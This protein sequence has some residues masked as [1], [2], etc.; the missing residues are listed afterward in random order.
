MDGRQLGSG[1]A[2]GP[3]HDTLYLAPENGVSDRTLASEVLSSSTNT[4]LGPGQTFTVSATVRVPG[5]TEGP[6][7]WQVHV[8]S[9]GEVFEGV[10]ANNN[11]ASSATPM[12]LTVTALAVESTNSLTFAGEGVASWFKIDQAANQSVLVDLNAATTNGR[13]R[14][15]AGYDTMP[16]TSAYDLRSAAWNSA[17]ARVVLPGPAEARTAYLLVMPEKIGDGQM[18]YTLSARLA[19]FALT[20]LGCSGAGNSGSATVQLFGSG[21]AAGMTARLRSSGGTEIA[22]SIVSVVD[23]TTAEATFDLRGATPGLY[24][25]VVVEGG[26]EAS[27]ANAFT[28]TTASAGQVSVRLILPSAL[29]DGRAFVGYVEYENLGGSDVPAALVSVRETRGTAQLWEMGGQP[30]TNSSLSFLTVAQDSPHPGVVRPGTVY[31]I[32]FQAKVSS[33]TSADFVLSVFR[34]TDTLAFDSAALELSVRPASPH[35]LWEAAWQKVF[36]NIGPTWGGYVAA[37]DAAANRAAVYGLAFTSADDVLR[38]MIQEAI[39]AV[40]VANV[41]GTVY[42]VDTNHPLGRVLVMLSK[43]DASADDT[44]TMFATTAWYDGTFGVRNMTAGTYAVSVDGYLMSSEQTFTLV[45]PTNAPISGLAVFVAGAAASI[46]GTVTEWFTAWRLPTRRSRRRSG[47]TVR[48][49]WPSPTA[50]EPTV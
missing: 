42:L 10:N 40:Q 14:I 16:T 48:F 43:V 38:F 35:P 17:N 36:G 26:D 30:G 47:A 3:W 31:R 23:S 8:N 22:A 19:T 4:I 7:L 50:Q 18:G 12:Q 25:V 45:D 9:R 20:A 5:G 6:Y 27:L 24:S 13:C 1:T 44:N 49:T 29:R 21:F 28:V 11:E 37:L 15:Y 2:V 32:P 46:H 33:S 34:T 41:S 39:E